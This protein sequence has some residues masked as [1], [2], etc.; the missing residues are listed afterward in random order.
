[1]GTKRNNT[2]WQ[3]KFSATKYCF[4]NIFTTINRFAWMSRQT[5]FISECV[6]CAW[7]LRM[8]PVFHIV[9]TTAETL[10]LPPCC[11]Y[12][13][14]LVS[15]NVQHASVGAGHSA[16]ATINHTTKMYQYCWE[17]S[18]FTVISLASASDIMGQCKIGGISYIILK[19]QPK[20]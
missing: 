18:T 11:A 5:L 16:S 13:W 14:C 1:M 8:W 6:S 17:G 7:L 20:A 12:N 10:D 19:V 15:I 3:S 2:V 4:F 9:V